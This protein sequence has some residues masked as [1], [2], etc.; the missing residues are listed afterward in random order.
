MAGAREP[1]I[2][3]LRV[4]LHPFHLMTKLIASY[5]RQISLYDPPKSLYDRT[6][7]ASLEKET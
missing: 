5:D 4:E 2:S 1:F 6:H 3:K 7:T